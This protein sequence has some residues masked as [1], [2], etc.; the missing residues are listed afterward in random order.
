MYY[1]YNAMVVIMNLKFSM[2]ILWMNSRKTIS[3]IRLQHNHNVLY[4]VRSWRGYD[5]FLLRYPTNFTYWYVSYQYC[6]TIN[7][8]NMY[9][10]E[11]NGSWKKEHA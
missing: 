10:N 8:V 1:M 6:N 4:C 11:A 9:K 5:S 7:T 2:T 3:D